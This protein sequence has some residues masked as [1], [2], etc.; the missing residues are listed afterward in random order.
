MP[1]VLQNLIV[2]YKSRNAYPQFDS[3]YWD[4]SKENCDSNLIVMIDA[5]ISS[6]D[7]Q[8]TTK[9][10]K[11]LLRKNLEQL[12]EF[13]I[14]KYGRNI[15]RNYFTWADFTDASIGNLINRDSATQASSLPILTVHNGFSISES[16]KHNILIQ[17]MLNHVLDNIEM[18]SNL[19]KIQSKGYIFGDHPHLDSEYGALTLDKLSSIIEIGS[20]AEVVAKDEAPC[21]L[22]IGAGSGRTANA[23]LFLHP[24]AKYVIADIPPASFVAMTRLKFAFPNKR[25]FFAND[26]SDVARY[27][28]S[29]EIWDVLFV[30]PSV[31]EAFP[32]KY[33]DL[34]LAIDCLHEMNYEMRT[35][36][37]LIASKKSKHYYFKIW[38]S[39]TIPLD[40]LILDSK[41][42]EDYGCQ[43]DWKNFL[44]RECSFPSN[45]SEFLFK[46]ET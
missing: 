37:A 35:F 39:T 29:P 8:A 18:T 28:R 3:E 14:E 25:I 33:F 34:T 24:N 9:Y 42:L 5:F 40:N 1:P 36:F 20:F 30:L 45:F 38:N 10:W 27:L 2:K 7:F 11:Y 17:L 15:A 13:G 31:L 43:P 26:S 12:N 23:L 44:S 6:P 16:I 21:I 22:E 19:R 46:I 4:G 32:G 41:N